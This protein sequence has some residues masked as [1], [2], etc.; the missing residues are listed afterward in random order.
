M[1]LPPEKIFIMH[2]KPQF[3]EEIETEIQALGHD[4][5]G[6]LRD[7]DVILI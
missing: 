2:I 6:F 7:G 3:L 5:I 4:N 1:P